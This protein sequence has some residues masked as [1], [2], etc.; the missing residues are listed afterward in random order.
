M[1]GK[2]SVR[3][4]YEYRNE[5]TKGEGPAKDGWKR[6]Q[7]DGI[8][9]PPEKEPMPRNKREAKAS[10]AKKVKRWVAGTEMRFVKIVTRTQFG[11]PI[12]KE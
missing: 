9:S 12:V 3:F 10:L 5:H 6:L 11:Q 7:F 2:L 8:F 4:E 1:A